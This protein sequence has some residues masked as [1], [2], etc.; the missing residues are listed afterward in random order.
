MIDADAAADLSL[1]FRVPRSPMQA[2]DAICRVSEWWI[3]E[4]EGAAEAEGAMFTYQYNPYHRTVQQ[5]VELVPGKRIVWK[6]L[7]SSIR[8]V[9]DE[10]EWKGT[11]LVFEIAERDGETEVRFTHVGLTPKLEC[12][13]NCSSGWN[14]Y[15]ETSL[16]NLLLT[17]QGVDPKW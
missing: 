15:I 1:S 16:P 7:E 13:G 8:F 14:H 9:K 17:G 3:G 10:G 2:F 6:I 5:V 4:V 12:Y 11:T